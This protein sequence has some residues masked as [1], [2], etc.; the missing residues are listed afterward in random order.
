MI[1]LAFIYTFS[2][3]ILILVVNLCKFIFISV[4]VIF[5]CFSLNLF[6]FSY[7]QGNILS[8]RKFFTVKFNY[9]YLIHEKYLN[10]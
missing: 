3:F 5:L 9:L 7:C 6:Y 10:L 1:K 8:F 4:F 2:V